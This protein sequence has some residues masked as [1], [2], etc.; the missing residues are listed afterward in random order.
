MLGRIMSRLA[1]LEHS[2]ARRTA[3]PISYMSLTAAEG[4]ALD[5]GTMDANQNAQILARHGLTSWPR[6]VKTYIEV[7]PDDWN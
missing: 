2:Q 1:K 3:P 6:A 5:A 4:E 7:S